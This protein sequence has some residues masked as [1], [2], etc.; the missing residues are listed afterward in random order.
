MSNQKL[1]LVP[2]V[3]N[4]GPQKSIIE[5]EI[6]NE[7]VVSLMMVEN[8]GW[9]LIAKVKRK[10]KSWWS[11]ASEENFIESGANI[12]MIL[13]KGLVFLDKFG[14][15]IDFNDFKEGERIGDP[16]YFKEMIKSYKEEICNLTKLLNKPK[17]KKHRIVFVV[18]SSWIRAILQIEGHLN[19]MRIYPE[20]TESDLNPELHEYPSMLREVEENMQFFEEKGQPQKAMLFELWL[21]TLRAIILPEL[22]PQIIELWNLL[23]TS[24]EAW[25]EQLE[26]FTN[27]DIR[28]GIDREF[29]RKTR[30]L[31]GKILESLPP[32]EI[33]S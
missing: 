11:R 14:Y 17:F 28:L 4:K 24:K 22:K 26:H 6:P 18:Y 13:K 33:Y 5:W 16:E 7:I 21:H 2:R 31:A 32:K 20:L 1:K 9:L 15:L 29:V 25:D 27:E 8:M 19:P 23:L 10:K 30:S 3:E 12:D